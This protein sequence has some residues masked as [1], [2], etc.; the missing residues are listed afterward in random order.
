MKKTYLFL[1]FGVI[2]LLSFSFTLACKDTDG[3]NFFTKGKVYD[4]FGVYVDFCNTFNPDMAIDYICLFGYA[5]DSFYL[6]PDGCFDGA[7]ITACESETCSSL[8]ATCGVQ[9]DGCGGT[10]DCGTCTTGNVC[11]EDTCVSSNVSTCGNGNCLLYEGDS[12]EFNIPNC[13]VDI[14]IAWD[15]LNSVYQIYPSW[16]TYYSGEIVD[17]DHE[18]AILDITTQILGYDPYTWQRIVGYGESPL[19]AIHQCGGDRNIYFSANEIYSTGYLGNPLPGRE[20]DAWVNF[21]YTVVQ[22]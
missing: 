8:G 17:F 13:T 21:A 22:N 5:V 19:W 2:L 10:L 14:S 6:C 15:S 9:S 11:Q 12:V 20:G 18:V 4:D 1:V 7:C 16:I 3:E